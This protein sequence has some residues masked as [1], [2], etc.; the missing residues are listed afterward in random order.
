LKALRSDATEGDWSQ[1]YFCAQELS[2]RNQSPEQ[3]NSMADSEDNLNWF[4]QHCTKFHYLLETDVPMY[5]VSLMVMK[6]I[7]GLNILFVSNPVINDLQRTISA[8][9]K[10]KSK[11]LMLYIEPIANCLM[12][13]NGDDSF[14]VSNFKA[15]HESIMATSGAA[16]SVVSGEQSVAA[17]SPVVSGEKK[18]H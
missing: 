12:Q 1:A 18:L 16:T 13:L 3:A 9:T 10:S 17:A 7:I 8:F 6:H 14:S 2:Y 4:L 15:L 11:H 5:N